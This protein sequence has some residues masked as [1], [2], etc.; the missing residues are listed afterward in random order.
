M[1]D[2]KIQIDITAKDDASKK[3]DAVA[4][5]AGD[6]EKLSPEVTVAADTGNAVA[7]IGAVADAAGRISHDD[8]VLVIK[9]Q[10]DQAKG[11]LN[12]LQTELKNTG[13][14]A[15]TTNR[16]LDDTTGTAGPGNLRGNAISDLTGPLGDAS[17][18]A[19]DFAGVFDGLGDAAE[20]AAGKLGLSQGVADKLGSAI[21]GLGVAVA[22]GAAIWTLWTQHAEAARKKAKELAE[23]QLALGEALIDGNA[24]AA[25]S[26]F[27]KLYDD[28]IA[29]AE[30]YGLK[31][32]DVINFITGQTD[33]IP[34]LTAK[35][36]ELQ[37]EQDATQARTLGAPA[38]MFV[39][40][41][42]HLDEARDSYGGA[43]G[44]AADAALA[45]KALDDALG[46][47][48]T[49]QKEMTAAVRDSIP[50]L[51]AAEQ[52]VRDLEAGYSSLD[53][54]LSNKRAIEDFQ[55][56]M[57]EAQKKVAGGATLTQDEVRGIEDAIRHAG[58]VAGLTP[59]EVQTEIDRV[60]QGDIDGAFLDTQRKIDAKGPLNMNVK[61]HPELPPRLKIVTRGG[62]TLLD[63]A[64]TP[65]ASAA[66]ASSAPSTIV[67]VQL[68]R[69]VRAG[70]IARAVG[71]NRRRNG[72][73][74]GVT[75]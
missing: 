7:D 36:H 64:L 54:R 74:F 52:K 57:I 1:A 3:I 13:E 25:R 69:G 17:G 65:I 44:K 29:S 41:A 20:A 62:T 70:D 39:E 30:R 15:D 66:S 68:P 73:R 53:D 60:E 27:H 9:A 34:G 31:Q 47:T 67:N 32:K 8:T 11:E 38:D 61:I 46:V 48:A 51:D 28:A 24:E 63:E 56:A 59:I 16:K 22:A 10:I 14:A 75:A 33:A 19:S 12:A 4:D 23:A 35:Y 26:N 18:A 55:N 2:E 50:K 37:A 43:A 49:S 72:R 71:V 45:N 21:G 58:E 42:R 5:S 6:L 40:L